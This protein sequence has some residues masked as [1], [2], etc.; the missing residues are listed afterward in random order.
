MLGNE[1]R[2]A[3]GLRPRMPDK[4]LETYHPET[5]HLTATCSCEACSAFTPRCGPHTRAVTYM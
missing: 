3:S 5:T 1:P 2:H 4:P